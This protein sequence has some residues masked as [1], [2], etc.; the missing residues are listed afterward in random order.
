[1]QIDFRKYLG[2]LAAYPC[3]FY[4]CVWVHV[5]HCTHVEDKRKTTIRNWFS[6]ST[7]WV[8][9]VKLLSPGL[10][11]STFTHW[12]ISPVQIWALGIAIAQNW[13]VA[14]GWTGIFVEGKKSLCMQISTGESRKSSTFM[15]SLWRKKMLSCSPRMLG[16][17]VA[18]NVLTLC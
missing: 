17:S 7:K 8:S 9:G 14:D 15:S 16:R 5:C 2:H 4:T 13:A 1:M 3:V 6:L 18:Y 11:T 12:A 10:A